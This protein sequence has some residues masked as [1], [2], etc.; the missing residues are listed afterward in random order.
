MCLDIPHCPLLA[1]IYH[2]WSAQKVRSILAVML[3]VVVIITTSYILTVVRY[4]ESVTTATRE[5]A[6]PHQLQARGSVCVA[7]LVAYGGNGVLQLPLVPELVKVEL[8][9]RALAEGSHAHLSGVGADVKVLHH[10]VDVVLYLDDEYR[11]DRKVRSDTTC[12]LHPEYG[13]S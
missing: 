9:T 3:R 11:K 2:D 6:R 5:H 4:S 10:V 12:N 7:I 1:F 13:C 8:R